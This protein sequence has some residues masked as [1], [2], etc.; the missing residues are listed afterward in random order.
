MP[1]ARQKRLV[2]L[3]T[4]A[5]TLLFDV[6]GGR[7]LRRHFDEWVSLVIHRRHRVRAVT[8]LVALSQSGGLL[9]HLHSR[10]GSQ[11]H[12]VRQS[13]RVSLHMGHRLLTPP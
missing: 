12:P 7:R 13:S 5:A 2:S 8:L 3:V 1:M 10:L 11:T 9:L 6:T 4:E